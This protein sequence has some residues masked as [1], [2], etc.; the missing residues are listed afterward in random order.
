MHMFLIFLFH[1]LSYN[2]SFLDFLNSQ[3]NSINYP[4]SNFYPN[5]KHYYLLFFH[6][7]S[8]NFANNF[9]FL[10]LQVLKHLMRILW[11]YF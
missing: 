6:G 4:L 8:A 1:L 10:M 5:K 2:F 11:L 7:F 9:Y 3:N